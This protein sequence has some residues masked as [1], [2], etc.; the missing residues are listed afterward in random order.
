MYWMFNHTKMR[1]ADEGEGDVQNKSVDR[2]E[3][4]DRSHDT[5]DEPMNA[6]LEQLKSVDRTSVD[7]DP[8]KCSNATKQTRD[9]PSE[10][11]CCG[12]KAP[13]HWVLAKAA[14][15]VLDVQSHKNAKG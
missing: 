1:K 6:L 12:P 14:V 13:F 9:R 10:W 3:H 15:D 8:R 4:E 11:E 5:V 2:P 7:Q